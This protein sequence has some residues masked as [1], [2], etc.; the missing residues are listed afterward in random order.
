MNS[1]TPT[2][3]AKVKSLPNT[4][5]KSIVVNVATILQETDFSK[6]LAGISIYMSPDA[7]Y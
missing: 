1:V 7:S 4:N 3:V 2:R 5:T 6:L